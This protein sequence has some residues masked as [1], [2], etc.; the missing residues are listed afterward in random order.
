MRL[1]SV[2]ILFSS[3]IF[4]SLITIV[5]TKYNSFFFPVVLLSRT[6]IPA[7]SYCIAVLFRNTMNLSTE[8][9]PGDVSPVTDYSQNVTD[10]PQNVTDLYE[11]LEELNERYANALIPVS[12]LLGIFAVTGI[13][14]NILVLAVFTAA[15][16]YKNNNFRIFVICLAII[17]LITCVSLVPA[18]MAKIRSHFSFPSAT[19][20]KVKCFFNTF[21]T[22]AAAFVLL[23]ISVDRFRKVCQPLKRQIVPEQAVK[24]LVAVL[25]MAFLLSFPAPILCGISTANKTN[26][27]NTTTTV[28]MCTAEK[29]YQKSVWRWLYKSSLTVCL[30]IV[31][32]ALI[33][34]YSLIGRTV[35][36]HWRSRSSSGSVRFELNKSDE[37]SNR[38]EID[39]LTDDV[40]T[41]ND[42]AVLKNTPKV[43][44]NDNVNGK[45][46]KTGKGGKG[47]IPRKAS[48]ISLNSSSVKGVSF[49]R[50]SDARKGSDASF[51]AHAMRRRSSTTGPGKVPYKT[52]IWLILTL[53]F[54]CTY[55]LYAILS[56]LVPEIYKMSPGKFMVYSLFY[57]LYFINNTINAAVYGLL[58]KR[59]QNSCKRLFAIL[60]KRCSC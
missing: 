53:V 12:V 46:N 34:M 42:I 10:Y 29:K 24:I 35:I 15:S 50:S 60:R 47:W 16:Q 11:T 54:I 51:R 21:G 52:L 14:G 59:F 13:L 40:F 39:R 56:F 3:R 19:P 41:P 31:S 37:A 49:P 22:A 9:F 33:V 18:E 5:Y 43:S 20:C 1:N 48:S 7:F 28:Y 17:D 30:I 45:G 2:I 38:V 44:K 6:V 8:A 26:M 23:V 27:Y 55:L 25:I 58:D 57:R 32:V 36:R 4:Y